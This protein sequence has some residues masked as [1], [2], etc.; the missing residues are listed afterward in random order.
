LRRLPQTRRIASAI[1]AVATVLVTPPVLNDL[2]LRFHFVE[3]DDDAHLTALRARSRGA[4][5]AQ[6][7]ALM[8]APRLERSPVMPTFSALIMPSA[9]RTHTHLRQR[10]GITI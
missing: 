3:T 6:F 7:D 5:Y 9:P 8:S 2:A 10:A 1:V 4:R